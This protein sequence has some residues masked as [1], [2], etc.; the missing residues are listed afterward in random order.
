MLFVDVMRDILAVG[1]L[2]GGF[3]MNREVRQLIY[4]IHI[5]LEAAI[6]LGFLIGLLPFAFLWSGGWVLPLTVIS[7]ILALLFYTRM[8]LTTGVNIL[9]ALLGYIPLL[10]YLPRILG[11]LIALYHVMIIRRE[12][13]RYYH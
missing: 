6:G 7:F 12:I 10:G 11:I 8:T 3:P 2:K 5:I 9:M 13:N 4:V 1:R